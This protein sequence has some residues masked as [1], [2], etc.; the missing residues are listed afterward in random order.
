VKAGSAR[1]ESACSLV[2]V[3]SSF[4]ATGQH[5]SVVLDQVHRLDDPR[6]VLKIVCKWGRCARPAIDVGR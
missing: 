5:R 1:E 2:V 3:A 4:F 6:G